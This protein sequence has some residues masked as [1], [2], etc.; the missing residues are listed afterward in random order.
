MAD[1]AGL[2]GLRVG[3]K[4]DE[5]RSG[6]SDGSF[7][8]CWL[9]LMGSVGALNVLLVN[10]MWEKLQDQEAML[11]VLVAVQEIHKR[12]PYEV[13]Y[14]LAMVG[15]FLLLTVSAIASVVVFVLS[16]GGL[17]QMEDSPLAKYTL[18]RKLGEGAYGAVYRASK[19]MSG[20]ERKDFAL[21]II[22]VHK[23]K[24]AN[25]AIAE[26]MRLACVDHRCVVTVHEH[27]FDKTLPNWRDRL[28]ANASPYRLCIA[29]ELCSGDLETEIRSWGAAAGRKSKEEPAKPKPRPEWPQLLRIFAEVVEGVE[30]LH[31]VGIIHRDVKPANIFVSQ[32]NRHVRIGDLG[33]AEKV[34][35][36]QQDIEGL[37][38]AGTPGYMAPEV[39]AGRAYS[40]RADNWSLGCVLV[41][42]A[43]PTEHGGWSAQAMMLRAGF[44]HPTLKAVEVVLRHEAVS[45]N[46]VVK[47]IV[48]GCLQEDPHERWGCEDT[49]LMLQT[50]PRAPSA[51]IHVPGQ[52][53]VEDVGDFP[54][55]SEAAT[56]PPSRP[57]SARRR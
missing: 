5:S 39:L 22:Q 50:L 46:L 53:D 23:V 6:D 15:I 27:F 38:R 54:E 21:K 16:G 56:P 26:A 31:K 17:T 1:V 9:P 40:T 7:L 32:D 55:G 19:C 35:V 34:Y 48:Q 8:S 12:A 30:A 45:D 24:Q 11:P 49:L 2:A 4:L 18:S 10:Q 51:F 20:G 41:D 42:M 36:R 44:H 13:P 57:Q 43:F 37:G 3:S 33:I 52:S 14:F 29:Q 47:D 25:R 28:F